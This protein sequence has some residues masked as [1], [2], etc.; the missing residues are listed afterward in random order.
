MTTCIYCGHL[1]TPGVDEC[2]DCKAPL[3][4]LHLEDPGHVE[5]GILGERIA[6]LVTRP[7]LVV[8]PDR[9][10]GDVL[11][12]LA[13]ESLGCVLVVDGARIVGIFSERDALLRLNARAEALASQPVSAF[14]TPDPECLDGSAKIAFALH[15]MDLGGYRHVPVVDADGRATGVIS[16]RDVLRYLTDHMARAAG[17]EPAAT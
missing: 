16:I 5:Q 9:P 7:P 13:E 3:S 10:V 2:V 8:P 12:L 14:M 11:T 15:R 4:D 17:P 1:N 6:M